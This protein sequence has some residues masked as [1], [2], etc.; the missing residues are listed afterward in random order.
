[1]GRVFHTWISNFE[2]FFD[3]AVMEYN[4]DSNDDWWAKLC[5]GEEEETREDE[6]EPKKK[7][8]KRKRKITSELAEVRE[9]SEME[10]LFR[11]SPP[12]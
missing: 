4:P 8:K 12:S 1:M 3:L 6:Q 5:Q 2:T 9:L 11:Y 7:R 10:I